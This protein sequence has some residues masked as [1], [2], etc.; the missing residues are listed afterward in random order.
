[1]VAR[2]EVDR[3]R[4]QPGE[5][6]AQE[7]GRV[8][9]EPVLFVEVTGA[10]TAASTRSAAASAQIVTGTPAAPVGAPR[11]TSGGA[12][13]EGRLEVQVGEQQQ[14]HASLLSPRVAGHTM[15]RASDKDASSQVGSAIG[16]GRVT[17]AAGTSA[18]AREPL[19][20]YR[21]VTQTTPVTQ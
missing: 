12:Q 20:R 7:R 16:G 14:P 6:V 3:H 10:D 19:E 2:G 9:G 21:D 4:V 15:P 5:A 1:M 13:R 11:A 8:R 17:L 18:P